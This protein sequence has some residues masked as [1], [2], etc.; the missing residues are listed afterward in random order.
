M[1]KM[2]GT[3][4]LLVLIALGFTAC[5][6]EVSPTVQPTN[7]PTVQ[8]E[9][10]AESTSQAQATAEGSITWTCPQDFAGQT[11]AVYNWGDYIGDTTIPEF[12][13]LCNVRVSLDFFDTNES[14][15]ARMRQGNPGYDVAFPNDYAI[16]IMIREALIQKLNF[17][18]IPNV[19]NVSERWK[20]QYFDPNNEYGVPYLFSSYGIAYNKTKVGKEITSWKELY[21][22][23]GAVVWIDDYRG[24]FAPAFLMN[25][26]SAST[27]DPAEIEIAFDYLREHTRNVIAVI[28]GFKESLASGEADM[29][30]TYSAQ[31]F[32]LMTTCECDDFAYVVP[33]E[34]GIIDVTNAVILTG[35]RNV[36]LAEA[37]I[38]YLNDPYVAAQITNDTAYPTTNRAAV[39]SGFINPDYLN[40]PAV[41]VEDEAFER[42]E[43]YR[44]VT[45]VEELYAQKWEE[46]LIQMGR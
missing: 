39:E 28:G 35:A 25:G 19:K 41:F 24:A 8:P 5:G 30:M 37:F 11:L 42:L 6:G 13:R 38:D 1:K 20:N 21:E 45:E 34:G 22:Y 7:P 3:V 44:P 23:E 33:V 9:A 43:F 40:N 2:L 15:I 31:A 10:T 26:F 46:L 27:T 17:D 16:E 12:E 18:N 14:L 4:T 29:M 32:D 36:P